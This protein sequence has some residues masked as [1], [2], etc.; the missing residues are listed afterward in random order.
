[1]QN[2]TNLSNATNKA[3]PIVG[4]TGFSESTESV[5]LVSVTAK[6]EETIAYCARVSNPENQENPDYARLLAYCV[7]HGHWSIFEQ[8]NLV[9]E[10]ET[11][12]SISTQI[13]RHRSFSFQEFSQ[14]Y[15]PASSAVIYQARRQDAK[16]RQNSIDDFD[17]ETQAWF[18]SA[19]EEVW[20]LAF[21]RYQEALARGVAKECAR[22]LLP[23]NTATR[24]YMNGTVRSWIHYIELRTANGTQLE[25]MRIAEK[26]K[27]IFCRELPTVAKALGWVAKA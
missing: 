5:R 18:A 1:M 14:R 2:E 8:A 10:I 15:A 13:L 24:L 21:S 7:K 19:Q 27:E 12:R 16:N 11:S 3:M 23:L 6:A 22:V 20:N 26:C 17:L 4:N 9:I 25:H